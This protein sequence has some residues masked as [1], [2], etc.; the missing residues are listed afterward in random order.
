[1]EKL[2]I[3]IVG[4]GNYSFQYINIWLNHPLIE[5]V[6]GAEFLDDRRKQVEDEY[7]IKTYKSFDEMLENE[8]DL[9]AVAIFTGRHMHGPQVIKALNMG[10]NVFSAVPMAVTEEEIVEILRL[11]EK[12]RLTYMMA[13][14]CYYFPCAVWCR[15]QYKQGKFGKFQYGESQYYHDISDMFSAFYAS[16]VNTD[17]SWKWFA[18]IPPMYYS[19][20]STSMLY[21]V[22]NEYPVEVSCYGIRDTYNDDIYGEDKNEW[23]NPYSN[24]TSIV[25]M[26]GGGVARINEFRRI[27]TTKPSSYLSSLYGDLGGYEYS[28]QQHL[29]SRNVE[30]PRE[31]STEDVSEQVNTFKWLEDRNKTDIDKSQLI[32]DYKYHCGF[33]PCQ[34]Y[35]RLPKNF[36]TF[37]EKQKENF[38][39]GHNGSHILLVDDFVRSVIT[40]KLPPVDPWFAAYCTLTGIYAHKSSMMGGVPVKI[41]DV[42]HKPADWD[43]IDFDE[44]K[45]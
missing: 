41:P 35:N 18:G 34:N 11:V 17:K 32:F 15:E 22:I 3:G 33:S 6:V 16:N 31:F 24:Q 14:T 36:L 38:M 20:H 21:S 27:G 44:I 10:K 4:F 1:M 37:T 40:K 7:K 13:E 25:R 5:K 29:F 12:T 19:T 9:N 30:N 23:G 42:G 28:G 26:S 2:K 8:S 43:Y 45:Y 39:H